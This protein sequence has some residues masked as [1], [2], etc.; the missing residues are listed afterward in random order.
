VCIDHNQPVLRYVYDLPEDE[1]KVKADA[2]MLAYLFVF[3]EY[4]RITSQEGALK[5]RAYD[6][7]KRLKN[8]NQS[9]LTNNYLVFCHF[10]IAYF[11]AAYQAIVQVCDE[12]GGEMLR[13]LEVLLLGMSQENLVDFLRLLILEAVRQEE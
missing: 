3:Q 6:L 11:T 9:W 2:I 12:D 1:E 4:P 5:E 13:D 10:F 8:C 7:C